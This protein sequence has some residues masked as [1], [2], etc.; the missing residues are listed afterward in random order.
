M[1][2]R[3]LCQHIIADTDQDVDTR[4][5]AALV[6]QISAYADV[7]SLRII[8]NES[9]R[10]AL[11]VD[12]GHY[13]LSDE[14]I[15]DL[16]D[17]VVIQIGRVL[18][19]D[20][21]RII[22]LLPNNEAVARASFGWGPK[23]VPSNVMPLSHYMLAMH[24]LH[25]G[26]PLVIHTRAAKN[27]FGRHKMRH[28]HRLAS[29][30]ILI[31]PGNAQPYGLLSIYCAHDRNF[32]RTDLLFLEAVVNVIAKAITQRWHRQKLDAVVHLSRIL[33]R[34]AT[35]I[36][37]L[38]IILTHIHAVCQSEGAAIILRNKDDQVFVAQG[39]GIWTDATGMPIPDVPSPSLQVIRS[40]LP[41]L[42]NSG[43]FPH[44]SPA[45]LDYSAICVVLKFNEQPIGALWVASASAI[46]Y[47]DKHLLMALADVVA[48]AINRSDLHDQTIKLYQ[49]HQDLTEAMRQTECY[50]ASIVDSTIDLVVS[51]NIDG[52]I[53]T[54]NRAAEQVSGFTRT[55]MVGQYLHNLCTPGH[56]TLMESLIKNILAGT[57][58]GEIELP[59]S[60]ATGKRVPISWHLSAILSDTGEHVGIVA[61]GRDLQKQRCLESQLFQAAKMTSMGV[62]ASGIGHELH[63]P[64][65]IISANAQL[66]LERPLD[67][68]IVQTCLH[69]IHAATKRAALIIDNLLTFVRPRSE[70]CQIVAVNE[71][72]SAG[73]LLLDYQIQQQQIQLIM[74]LSNA[75]PNVVG[76]AGLLQQVFINVILNALQAMEA[77][78][79]LRITTRKSDEFG[80]EVIFSDTGSG[81]APEV[82]PQIFDPFFT[83]RPIGKG[84]GLG[85]AISYSIIQQHG[86]TIKTSSTLGKGSTFSIRLP[87]AP[88]V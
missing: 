6:S 27:R 32:T 47:D 85:L 61:V 76:N 3:S 25:G 2:S 70:E 65:S 14:P 72:L 30:V 63:N 7:R 88:V 8:A 1:P 69:Q 17:W 84:T 50:L 86:G 66:A 21:C 38:T 26:E 58:S 49:D 46:S 82:L 74:T 40:G 43:D 79:T 64:L 56:Q 57:K 28:V 16:M 67:H 18:E 73:L 4:P 45:S 54:W 77:G 22:E 80:L 68:E 53:V 29:G 12:L 15:S 37:M 23:H 36:E 55:Q 83:T 39:H 44:E 34:A 9:Q 81:I 10:Q 24:T 78:G 41:F 48:C 71:V 42:G 51:T 5:L 52:R 13:A 62:M 20:R 11:L 31:I 87:A 75:I 33:R 19:V 60:S 35:R 59:L